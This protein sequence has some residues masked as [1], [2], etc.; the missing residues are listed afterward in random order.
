[1]AK[2]PLQ[3]LKDKLQKRLGSA[4]FLNPSVAYWQRTGS[5]ILDLATRNWKQRGGLP[6]GKYIDMYGKPGVGK[7]AFACR[8]AAQVQR[9]GGLVVYVNTNEQG[10]NPEYAQTMGVDVNEDSP[11]WML[12]N[13]FSLNSAWDALEEVVQSRETCD[14][15]TFVV[16]DSISGSAVQ[17]ATMDGKSNKEGHAA[18]AGA[19]FLHEAFRR[20]IL[21]YMNGTKITILGIRHQTDSPKMYSGDTVTHGSAPEYYS[22]LQFKVSTEP[23]EDKKTGELTGAWIKLKIRRSKVGIKGEEISMPFYFNR[24]FNEGLE[25]VWMLTQTGVLKASGG[26]SAKATGRFEFEGK[27]LFISELV[28]GYDQNEVMRSSLTQM[29]LDVHD[30][31]DIAAARVKKRAGKPK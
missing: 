21:Y 15:P 8:V 19:K 9:E 1:V 11:H 5:L 7:T 20:G 24:G 3:L 17:T 16:I 18:S 10:F 28:D 30:T 29:V 6:G 13:V 31:V 2:D 4:A 23:L 22:W 26:D 27:N 12:L 25:V 14:E